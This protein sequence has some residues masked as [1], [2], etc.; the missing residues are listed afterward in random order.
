[1]TTTLKQVR[2]ALNMT[3]VE[4]AE[5][6]GVSRRSYQ[7]YE[8][9]NNRHHSIKYQY[10]YEKLRSFLTDED[11]RILSIYEIKSGCESVFSEHDVDYCYLFGSYAKG[12]AREDS[13]VD[14]LISTS[15]TGLKFFGLME[16][17][18]ETMHK[19]VNVLDVG[20]LENNMELLHDILK[21]GVKIYG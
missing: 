5:F 14:L 3:Q 7:S 18:R 16:A 12:K 10:M 19:K 17:L 9:D 8:N 11:K 6:L 21:D 15:I 1:M 13:D 2:Q 20:Q 4:A